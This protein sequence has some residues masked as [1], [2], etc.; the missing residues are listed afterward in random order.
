[1]SVRWLT[2]IKIII[3]NLILLYLIYKHVTT[4]RGENKKATIYCLRFYLNMRIAGK[5]L[6]QAV[7]YCDLYSI[8]ASI[9]NRMFSPH[10]ICA[11]RSCSWQLRH[12]LSV[13]PRRGDFRPIENV[14]QVWPFSFQLKYNTDRRLIYFW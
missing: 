10:P 11:G 9:S 7:L 12:W 5:Y 3:V 6:Q 13:I 2:Q 14:P 8:N 4:C 1:M